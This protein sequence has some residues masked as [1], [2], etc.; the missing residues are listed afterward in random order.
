MS[1]FSHSIFPSFFLSFLLVYIILVSEAEDED[2]EEEDLEED[3]DLF[4]LGV[5]SFYVSTFFDEKV[6]DF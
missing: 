6:G 3:F 1:T 5:V 2:E 4:F